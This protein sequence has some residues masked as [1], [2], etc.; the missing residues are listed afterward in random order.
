MKRK[1]VGKFIVVNQL[2]ITILN[3]KLDEK[4]N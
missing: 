3:Q 2:L 1:L 4:K